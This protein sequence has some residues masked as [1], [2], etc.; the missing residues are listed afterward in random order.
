MPG[1]A[2]T[3]CETGRGSTD[4]V[5]GV[6]T[7]PGQSPVNGVKDDDPGH[8][9]C[10]CRSTFVPWTTNEWRDLEVKRRRSVPDVYLTSPLRTGGV[11]GSENGGSLCQRPPRRHPYEPLGTGTP[12]E[13]PG[14][15]TP[16]EPR[17]VD[18][19]P[20]VGFRL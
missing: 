6:T 5:E 8:L 12:T 13:G 4:R 9:T 1:T 3:T 10:Q 18:A 2:T 17:T 15:R 20:R 14:A 7:E 11:L 16:T 19:G